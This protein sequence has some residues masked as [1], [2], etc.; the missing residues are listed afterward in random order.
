MFPHNLQNYYGE[1]NTS[2]FL[3]IS[4]LLP[5]RKWIIASLCVAIAT[6]NTPAILPAIVLAL[7]LPG[8]QISKL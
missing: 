4:V 1:V 5:K 2:Q 3:T 7:F 8:T 6:L